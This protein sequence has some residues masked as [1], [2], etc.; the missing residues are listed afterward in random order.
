MIY[1]KH[2]KDD[3]IWPDPKTVFYDDLE[4]K[5]RYAQD[6]LS[7]GDLFVAAHVLSAYSDLINM[8]QKRR[9]KLCEEL[10]D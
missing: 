5:L 7:K 2:L 10:K 8:T 4:W 1:T 6:S 3:T 9:N